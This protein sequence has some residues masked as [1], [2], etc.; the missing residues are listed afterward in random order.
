MPTPC[1]PKCCNTT[2]EIGGIQILHARYAHH[3]I[4]CSACGCV[5][6]LEERLSLTYMLS[7]IAEK[8]GVRFD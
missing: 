3:A 1:C 5:V 6:G 7:K 2:F 8:L 4:V